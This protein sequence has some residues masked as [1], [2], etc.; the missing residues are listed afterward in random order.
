[1]ENTLEIIKSE[2]GNDLALVN[3]CKYRHI[4]QRKDGKVKWRCIH[5][6][7]TV[8]I[9]TDSKHTILLEI[10]G[11]H[12]HTLDTVEKM[13]RQILRENCKRKANDTISVRP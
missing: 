4:R 12:K 13:Q 9:L 10:L 6:T 1:M 2:K 5:K 7:C 8:S 3:T 11:E